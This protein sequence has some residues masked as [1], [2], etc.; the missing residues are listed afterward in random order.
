MYVFHMQYVPEDLITL[1]INFYFKYVLPV[2][3]VI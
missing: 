3:Y 1:N 2:C